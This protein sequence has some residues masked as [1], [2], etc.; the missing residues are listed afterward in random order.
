MKEHI[1]TMGFTLKRVIPASPAQVY[2]AWIDPK[3]A[4]NPYHDT[5]KVIFKPKVGNLFFFLAKNGKIEI[6]HYGRFLALSPGKKVQQTW[7][8]RYT[9]GLESQVT[10]T[11]KKQGKDTLVTVN[12]KNLPDDKFGMMHHWGWNYYLDETQKLFGKKRK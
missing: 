3:I 7:M 11:F 9:R 1:K 8:S 5:M 2:K 4:C 12:Q 6:A 10:A